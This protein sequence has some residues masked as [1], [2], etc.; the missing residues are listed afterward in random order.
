MGS[1]A[2]CG[3][4]LK[5]ILDFG[6]LERL[7]DSKLGHGMGLCSRFTTRSILKWASDG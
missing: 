2:A 5:R 6:T 1:N 7:V 3:C 4:V